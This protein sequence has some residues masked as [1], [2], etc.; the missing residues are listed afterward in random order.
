MFLALHV[1][2]VDRF[3][4]KL[5]VP[6]LD[7]WEVCVE[8][9]IARSSRK[10]WHSKLREEE[11][12]Q[13]WFDAQ[14]AYARVDHEAPNL[15]LF[16]AAFFFAFVARICS[17]DLRQEPVAGRSEHEDEIDDKEKHEHEH[18]DEIDDEEEHEQEHEKIMSMSMSM[19]MQDL[20]WRMV[21][22]RWW[23]EDGG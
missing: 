10:A 18:E 1:F 2:V 21:D 23:I 6:S 14:G 22:G 3:P 17:L 7:P 12:H 5:A 19:S 13:R 9:A 15:R 16:S 20:G 8:V 4:A 11:P